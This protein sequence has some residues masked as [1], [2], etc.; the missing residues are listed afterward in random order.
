[1]TTAVF[2]RV[3]LDHP[4]P[5]LF[6]YRWNMST[7]AVP[8]TLVSVPFGK[9]DVVGLVCEVT[10]HSEVPADRLRAVNGV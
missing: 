2:V 1:M 6:D 5:T 3:A 10:A 8:G 4:L 7:A 9:R